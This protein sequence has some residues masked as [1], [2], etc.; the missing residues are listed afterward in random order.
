MQS[1]FGGRA[2]KTTVYIIGQ[3]L[4]ACLFQ[5]P[6]M[7]RRA[8]LCA[9]ER[10]ALLRQASEAKPGL[11]T[12]SLQPSLQPCQRLIFAITFAH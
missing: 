7:M 6:A 9:P 10:G 8:M 2:N 11:E 4:P 12:P 5:P 3:D 1:L